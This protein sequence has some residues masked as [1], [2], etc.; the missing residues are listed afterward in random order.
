MKKFLLFGLSLCLLI[1]ACSK[2][3]PFLS[4][5]IT[6]APLG[7]ELNLPD[8]HGKV[9]QL[10]DFE[11]K[12]IVLFFGFTHCP[13]ICPTTLSDM[14]ATMKKLGKQAKD[15]QV[16]FVSVDP[17]RDTNQLLAQYVPSF[18]PSFLALRGTEAE[19]QALAKRFKVYYQKQ[20]EGP[21][22]TIDHSSGIYIFDKQGKL[23]LLVNYGA[24]EQVL[25]HDIQLLLNE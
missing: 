5:D 9:R 23:R 20:G 14:T 17:E 13:D 3:A 15:V 10:A 8:F 24:G 19:T 12:V 16:I 11:G 18:Y 22:Y 7:G 2:K 6:G 1:T 21:Y 25:S 4:T